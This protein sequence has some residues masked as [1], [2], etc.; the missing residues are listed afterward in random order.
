MSGAVPATPFGRTEEL[1]GVDDEALIRRIVAAYQ[2]ASRTPLGSSDT[3]W[4]TNIFDLKRDLHEAML[5]GDLATT[6]AWLRKPMQSELMNGFDNM[7]ASLAWWATDDPHHSAQIY[8]DLISLAEAVGVLAFRNP[9]HPEVHW[10]WPA[11]EPLLEALDRAVGFRITF[12]NPFAGEIGLATSRGV[13]S[14]RA[15]QA[16]YQ[17]WRIA[18]LMGRAGGARIVEI[19]AGL[20]RTAWFAWCAGQRTYT[21]VDLP[22]TGA[23]QA[24][25]LGRV[26][27]ADNV[28]LFGE[29]PRPGIR[30]VPPVAFLDADDRYDLAVNVDSMPEMAR[31]TARQYV[32]TIAARCDNFLSINH[33]AN[34]FCVR[35]LLEGVAFAR[36][37][38]TRCWMRQGYVEEW[39]AFAP[40]EPGFRG[41]PRWLRA[42]L[43]K[44]AAR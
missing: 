4:L 41:V 7:A 31:E 28:C 17:A 37:A 24:Y 22:L 27:G 42:L 16:I 1:Q 33:E 34:S 9:E 21:V 29:A 23:A 8:H 38:R 32:G 19:G 15:V 18:T 26:I 12:P 6:A 2:A 20:G 11:V 10:P 30:I 36:Y 25:F 39:L 40:A 14:Y 43:P 13:A 3:R 44:A 5:A 35:E